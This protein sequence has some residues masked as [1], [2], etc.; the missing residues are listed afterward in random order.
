MVNLTRD[1]GI[2]NY[3]EGYVLVTNGIVSWVSMFNRFV[4]K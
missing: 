1:D 4:S 2:M 3:R